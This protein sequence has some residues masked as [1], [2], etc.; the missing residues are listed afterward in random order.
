[1]PK[2]PDDI[3]VD[4][5]LFSQERLEVGNIGLHLMSSEILSD[6][7]HQEV[8][9]TGKGKVSNVPVSCNFM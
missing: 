4:S 1:L 5:S 7:L 9:V 8:V 2:Q 3:A 6:I